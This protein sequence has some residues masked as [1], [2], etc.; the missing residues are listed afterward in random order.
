MALTAPPENERLIVVDMQPA[1]VDSPSP[2]A[3]P[4]FYKALAQV[5]RLLPAYCG[6][7]VLTPYVPPNA[8]TGA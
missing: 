8:L 2:W 6:R 5:E 7:A 1:F 4:Y 3:A